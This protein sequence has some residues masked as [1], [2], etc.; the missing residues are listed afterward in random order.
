MLL[1]F[2]LCWVVFCLHALA[3]YPLAGY[4]RLNLYHLYGLAASGGWLLG[5]VEVHRE[6]RFESLK[7]DPLSPR[8]RRR[9]F[10]LNLL[11]PGGVLFLVW[12]LAPKPMRYEYPMA[13]IYATGV[14]ALFFLVPVS[15]KRVFNSS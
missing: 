2:L 15:L 9:L 1:F 12:S 8:V 6:R 13:P 14:F 11:A 5:N 10:F 7:G 4:L 3:G